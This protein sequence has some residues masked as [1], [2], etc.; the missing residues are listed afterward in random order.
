MRTDA[1]TA[2]ETY[3]V[4]CGG[5]GRG[6]AKI[7]QQSQEFGQPP[8]KHMLRF[9]VAK[10]SV[11]PKILSKVDR[12]GD[13]DQQWYGRPKRYACLAKMG[14]EKAELGDRRRNW[15]RPP[16]VWAPTAAGCMLEKSLFSGLSPQFQNSAEA[17]PK[18]FWNL[19]G[20]QRAVLHFKARNIDSDHA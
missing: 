5:C 20:N 13:D 8:Q 9:V 2:A 3:V 6:R 14:Q 18:F 1:G 19:E 16:W 12:I 11:N 10:Q 15:P 7:V 17:L 4:V